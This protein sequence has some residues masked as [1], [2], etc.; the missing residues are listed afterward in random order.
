[1]AST[2]EVVWMPFMRSDGPAWTAADVDARIGEVT[3][4]DW[5]G[6]FGTTGPSRNVILAGRLT[7][8]P[9]RAEFLVGPAA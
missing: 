4:I 8:D 2:D 9:F 3:K 5:R 6:V 7:K 1:M